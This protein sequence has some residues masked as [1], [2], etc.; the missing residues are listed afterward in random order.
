MLPDKIETNL[1]SETPSLIMIHTPKGCF[2]IGKEIKLLDDRPAT[3]AEIDW[4]E[5]YMQGKD[6]TQIR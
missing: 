1:E 6:A 2:T 4:L 5:V 3:E